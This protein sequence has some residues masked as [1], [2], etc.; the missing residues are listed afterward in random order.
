[1]PLGC[2]LLGALLG[3]LAAGGAEFNAREYGAD[4]D[5]SG[6]D[7]VPLTQCFE[8][9][10]KAGGGIITIPPGDYFLS[11]EKPVPLCSRKSPQA[12]S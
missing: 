3:P 6:D 7:T 9:T 12:G 4:G 11:G 8:A 5:G 2:W 1:M 10:A